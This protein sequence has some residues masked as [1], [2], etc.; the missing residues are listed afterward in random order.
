MRAANSP[1]IAINCE[2]I[3]AQKPKG[4]ANIAAGSVVTGDVSPNSVV[5]VAIQLNL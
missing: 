5:G 2:R 1:G 4:V 3:W